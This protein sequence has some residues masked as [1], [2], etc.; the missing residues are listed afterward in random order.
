MFLAAIVL[1]N[2]LAVPLFGGRLAALAEVRA[3]L[4]WMLLVALGLQM[5]SLSAPGVPES[6]RPVLQLTSYPVAAV[7]VI[8]NRRLPGMPLI[9]LGSLLNAVAMSANGGVMPASPSALVAA[10]LP[11]QHDSYANSGVVDD[12]R[13]PF[14]GD[15]FAIPDPVPLHNVFSVGD[16]CI[17]LGAVVALHGLCGSRLRPR[18]PHGRHERPRRYRGRHL[19]STR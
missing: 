6:L 15:V 17:G 1:L 19:R 2:A 10:G 7:F 4:A 14:L 12:A 8:A 3:R 18:R 11:L 9:G 5:I 13:L 16:V